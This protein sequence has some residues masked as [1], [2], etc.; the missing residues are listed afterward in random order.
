M[1]KK[2]VLVLSGGGARGVLQARLLKGL[3][4]KIRSVAEQ[5]KYDY[6]DLGY[7]LDYIAGTSI[8]AINALNT[9]FK[10]D[11]DLKFTTDDNLSMFVD[12]AGKILKQQG[13][14]GLL[15]PYF[16][17]QKIEQ[18]VNERFNDKTFDISNCSGKI[19]INSFNLDT[20][21]K[22]I[23]TNIGCE[24]D[25][26]K[27]PGHVWD[28]DQ[29][30]LRDAAVASAAVPGLLSS[31]TIEY[32]RNNQGV[33]VHHEVDGGLHANSAI[34]ELV[35]DMHILDGVAFQDMFVL[36]IGSG[37]TN[38][39]LT[40]LSGKGLLDYVMNFKSVLR[41][42][43]SCIQNDAQ[44]RTQALIVSNGGKVAV[45]NPLLVTEQEIQGA[46][47]DTSEQSRIY[48]EV[49]ER[50]LAENDLYI[51]EL[52]EQIVECCF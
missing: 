21:T 27:L 52:A 1:K 11:N 15:E 42:M 44:T 24:E 12:N 13:L 10:S 50:Y 26:R 8:G 51:S 14:I 33:K 4:D 25:R 16:S 31:K 37:Y 7:H 29:I 43:L 2:L 9:I 48:I 46:M 20:C 35:N 30:K 23:F 18:I 34:S 19:L 6:K 22:T 45:L 40:N 28:I 3:N 39:S 49:A 41:G 36:S 5:K 32:A 17:S 47:N 38:M